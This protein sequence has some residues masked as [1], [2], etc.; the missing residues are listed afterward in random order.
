[1]SHD[2]RDDDGVYTR[3][4]EEETDNTKG[5]SKVER[6]QR[7][8][9][10]TRW[11]I[12]LFFSIVNL[13]QCL[14][15]FTF[16]SV[17]ADLM[18][19]YFG[20]RMTTENIDLLLNWGPII[21]TICF[22]L[23]THLLNSKDGFRRSVRLGTSLAFAGNLLRLLPILF[24]RSFRSSFLAFA[25]Y[26]IGQILNA[27]AGS[28]VMSAVTRLS[29]IWFPENER[30]T[31]TAIA[32]TSNGLG[33][34]V[35]FLLGPAL[36]PTSDDVPR[37]LWLGIAVA[38]IP[39]IAF[40]LYFPERP[41]AAPSVAAHEERASVAVT[42]ARSWIDS[43]RESV[44]GH[45]SYVVLIL[46]AGTL[47]GA[48]SAWQGMLQS[49]LNPVGYSDD[50]VGWMGFTNGLASAAFAIF[51]GLLIDRVFRKKM[52]ACI[53]LGV[54]GIFLSSV[55]FLLSVPCFLYED[56]APLPTSMS[57]LVVLLG[58]NGAATGLTSP[59]FYELA[60]ELLYP[61]KEGLS[62][63]TLVFV[64]NGVSTLVIV[65]DMVLS[66]RY[67]NFFYC[68]VLGGILLSISF[69]REEYKRP[70]EERPSDIIKD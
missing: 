20:E 19:A 66:Y 65:V 52:K 59:L 58:L 15:W 42:S 1:M 32:Q 51:G 31:A 21:G 17:D 38:A 43:V 4:E 25:L 36:V 28:F 41:H 26:H 14:S 68:I 40:S 46:S 57:V 18:K 11:W 45:P 29:S 63:G 23:Q 64:L 56:D 3:L 24:S 62:A 44:S 70:L 37:L 35:G 48:N 33:T 34:T 7:S 53:V 30:T 12:L 61:M 9:E 39:T 13:N 16:S 55:I 69:V 50:E 60:A 67:I 8:G 49:T 5:R 54:L 2:D 10:L 47:S 22:P 6:V 27:A